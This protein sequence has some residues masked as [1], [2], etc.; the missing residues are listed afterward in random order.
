M[1]QVI[2][3]GSGNGK[4]AYAEKII[5]EF[6]EG[7]RIYI[8]TM[9]PSG[10]DGEARVKRHRKLRAGKNFE[11]IECYTSLETVQ[12]PKDAI[13]LLESMSNLV[14]NE[15]FDIEGAH[16]DVPQKIMDGIASLRAQAKELIVVTDEVFSDGIQYDK[17]TETYLKVLGEVNQLLADK[18]DRITE[19]VCGIP[20]VIR[21]APVESI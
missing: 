18:C 11:T 7:K 3:G 8:A 6:G 17:Q 1:F 10:K 5:L 12:V 15:L 9:N 14:A 13:V 20:V 19:V 2:T 16:E 21:D 4:S